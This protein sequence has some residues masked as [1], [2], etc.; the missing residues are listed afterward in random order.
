MKSVKNPLVATAILASLVMLFVTA[1][2]PAAPV[3][4]LSPQVHEVPFPYPTIQEAIDAANDGDTVVVHPGTYTGA[5]NRDLNFNG[6]AI[7]VRSE[8]P[9]EEDIV[10][11]TIIDCDGTYLDPHRA[12]I[13]QSGED[14]NSVLAGFTIINGYIRI[15]GPDASGGETEGGPGQNSYGGAINCTDSSPTIRNC[16]IRNCVAE[17]GKGGKGAPGKPG[18][19]GDP[20][21]PNDPNDDILPIPPTEGGTGG[22]AGSGY[23]GAVY[24]DP[25]S[26]PTILNCLI[27]NCSALGGEGGEGG[28][29]GAGG[30][31]N[32]PHA[33][34]GAPGSSDANGYGGGIDIAAGS[35]AT[36]TNCFFI[37]CNAVAGGAGES[38]G[39]ALYYGAGYSGAFTGDANSC[40]AGYGAG[41]YCGANC[42]FALAG[43]T[44]AGGTGKYGTGVYCD[45]DCVLTMDDC[46]VID[47]TG[48]SGTGIYFGAD[49]NAT[50]S[51]VDILHHTA[52][53][54]GAGLYC[55]SNG[56]LTL[57][58][59][60]V[61]QSE[62]MGAGGAIYCDSDGTLTLNNC[63]VVESTAAGKGG[64][65]YCDSSGV[66]D[67]HDCNIT[68][69]TAG[70]DGGGIYYAGGPALTLNNCGLNDNHSL[71]GYGGCIYGGDPTADVV[72]TNVVII[73]CS[74]GNN[75]AQ[76]G[77]AICLSGT[78][79]VL[80]HS[81]LRNNTAEYGGGAFWYRS[82]ISINNC[83]I[84]GNSAEG[85]TYC[86]GGGLYCLDCSLS[87][88]DSDMVGNSAIGFGGA[89]FIIGPN[90]PGGAQEL[91]NCLI[92]DNTTGLD[93]A[94]LSCNVEAVLKMTN[95]T[96]VGNQ[97]LDFDGSGGGI[98]CYAASVEVINSILWNNAAQYGAEIAI[99]DPL[100][101]Y[102]P[103]ATVMLTY[104]DVQDGEEYV[105]VAPACMLNWGEGNIDADPCF[106]NGYHLIQIEAGDIADTNSPC[107][108]AGSD[109]AEALGLH[110]YTTRTDGA[111]DANI[112]DIGYHYR[113]LSMP[114]DLDFDGDVDLADL[115]ILLSYWL[116]ED[117]SLLDDCE[118]AD[119]NLDTD[120]DFL[121]YAI[122]AQAHAPVDETPPWPNPSTW[123]VE[124][125]AI[126]AADDSISMTATTAFDDVSGVEY[127]FV[128]TGGDG[129]DSG[130]QDSSTYI[131]TGLSEDITYTYKAQTRDKSPRKNRTAWSVEASAYIDLTPPTPNPSEWKTQPFEYY[132]SDDGKYYNRMEAV[133]AQDISGV[134]YY[135][136]CQT[137][138]Y[139]SGWQDS[140]I[141]KVQVP[142]PNKQYVYKVKTRDKSTHQ[143]ETDYSEL[144]SARQWP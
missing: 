21:D 6:L 28:T 71:Y 88:R 124:P 137:A 112:V 34:D 52:T 91:K 126:P 84:S 51:N 77:G 30:E 60:N 85:V 11:A 68:Q 47:G 131:D 62:A 42:T 102:N 59:C 122:C 33:P 4:G 9:D 123:A 10:A 135:F 120:V 130:W 20:G 93:G 36:V 70:G 117:C 106:I 111:P 89:V 50:I 96:V 40:E 129:H 3:S 79:S 41:I 94:G 82:K 29:G 133:M 56:V 53:G 57:N 104:S 48:D 119:L 8:D 25:D 63:N 31:P 78:N 2:L 45:A 73:N 118:G 61:M 107:V 134:E 16:I 19:P 26:G 1:G 46:L 24:C 66:L 7:T 83:A 86:S 15:D 136:W 49:C 138:G 76:Y 108:D 95:C 39:G 35:T 125:Y 127:R 116:Q 109:S 105:F 121:D 110:R 27:S 67:F 58:N 144:A 14:A 12:F 99:G 22:N 32:D 142:E 18:V 54:D 139:G 5:G 103:L 72:D 113:G 98:S 81:S 143:N 43:N 55:G 44:F 100:E 80:T 23:G 101:L 140:P 64:A 141:Y 74:I 115:R 17:G 132:N 92:T 65:I 75:S 13:F 87:I 97:V 128:C 90:L 69:S 38:R 37:D 114:C